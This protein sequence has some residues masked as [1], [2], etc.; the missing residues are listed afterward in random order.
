MFP[1]CGYVIV[2]L[3]VTNVRLPVANLTL[4]PVLKV[5]APIV[6]VIIPT[7]VLK[8]TSVGVNVTIRLSPTFTL[9]VFVVTPVMGLKTPLTGSVVLG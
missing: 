3:L 2:P 5:L 6:H 4:V 8:T 1:D 9:K 7:V